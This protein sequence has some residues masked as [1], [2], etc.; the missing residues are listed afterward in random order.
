MYFV[1]SLTRWHDVCLNT[2]FAIQEVLFAWEH[3]AINFDNVKVSQLLIF[4]D[5]Q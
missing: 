3:E 2:P 1:Y 4:Y 5:L